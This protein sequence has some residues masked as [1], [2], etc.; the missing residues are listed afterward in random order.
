MI[1]RTL[2]DH[3][4]IKDVPAESFIRAFA[5]QLK[6]ESKITPLANDAF[7]KTGIA[8]EVSPQDADWFYIR[9]AALARLIAL[10]PNTG[11]GRLRHIYGDS[12]RAGQ[13]KNHHK[14]GSGK[15]IRY[16]L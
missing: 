6:K 1:G 4:T 7:I 10:K 12:Q 8:K 16:A 9:T 13:G 5:E 11:V 15:I 14:A 3:V 2:R